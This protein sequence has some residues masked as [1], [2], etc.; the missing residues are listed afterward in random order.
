[1]WRFWMAHGYVGSGR[2]W[3]ERAFAAADRVPD[4]LRARALEGLAVLCLIG[5]DFNLGDDLTNESLERLQRAR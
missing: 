4:E 1:M 2:R 5:G 3:L